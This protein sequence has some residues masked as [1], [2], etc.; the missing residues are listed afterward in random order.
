VSSWYH[1]NLLICANLL[2]VAK[3][4]DR[5]LIF[6]GSGHAFL[7]RRCVTETPGFRLVEP[8]DYLPQ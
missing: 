5:I 6:F 1:R 8:N 2:Q 4:D 7:L 3:P